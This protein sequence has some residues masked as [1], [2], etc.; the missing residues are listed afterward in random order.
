MSRFLRF[1]PRNIPTVAPVPHRAVLS[2][3]G[4]DVSEFLNGILASHVT[5]PKAPRY[6]V[7][8]NAQARPGRVLYDVFLYTSSDSASKPIYLL[9]YDARSSDAPSLISLLKRYVLRS[10]VKIR[11]VSEEYDVWASWGSPA[12]SELTRQ[13]SWTHSGVIQPNW[14][15]LEW[16]WGNTNESVWDRRAPGMGKRLLVKKGALPQETSDHERASS[17]VY[18]L[19][20]IITG[21]PEGLED[22]PAM[23]A[24]PIESNMD[25]MGGLDFRKGCYVGQELTVRTYHTGSVRKRILPVVIHKTGLLPN[26]IVTPSP[27]APSYPSNLAISS[28]RIRSPDDTRSLPRPRGTGKLLTSSQGIG[29]ALLRLEQVEA[30]EQGEL[31]LGFNVEG[32]P[33]EGAWEI[34]HCWPDWWPRRSEVASSEH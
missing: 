12:I 4:S 30:A 10:K 34:Q 11:D 3:G 21:V 19:H 28:T 33:S 24:F 16:P 17:D 27:E 15:G 29:L 23:Q 2:L 6:S 32:G 26:P 5:E 25:I 13:W 1:L 22:I 8:L 14:E 9:D 18:T 7:F 31:S 20:R